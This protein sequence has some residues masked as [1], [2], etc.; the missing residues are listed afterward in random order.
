MR[1]EES[2]GQKE[3]CG[4]VYDSSARTLAGE[5][6]E[7]TRLGF[8]ERFGG[9]PTVGHDRKRSHKTSGRPENKRAGWCR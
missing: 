1:A 3:S 4:N 6:R 8:I 2:I 9:C 5:R 7:L